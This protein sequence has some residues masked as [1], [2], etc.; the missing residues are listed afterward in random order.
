MT[1]EGPDGLD[2][3]GMAL[4]LGQAALASPAAVAVH[5]DRDV[6]REIAVR[7]Q[8]IGVGGRNPLLDPRGLATRRLR[9][10][11]RIGRTGEGRPGH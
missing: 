2:A 9:R 3:G 8:P 7:Q 5:D 11:G 6:A 10:G 4:D 1:E